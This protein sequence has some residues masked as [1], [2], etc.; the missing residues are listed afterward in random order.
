MAKENPQRFDTVKD[1]ALIDPRPQ[2]MVGVNNQ[3]EV[4]ISTVGVDSSFEKVEHLEVYIP[5]GCLKE[6]IQ[7]LQAIAHDNGL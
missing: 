3:D 6:L 4:V 1:Y 2:I 7:S 5:L